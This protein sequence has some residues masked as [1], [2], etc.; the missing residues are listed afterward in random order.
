MTT[1]SA[2][3]NAANL[4]A[5]SGK[6]SQS[7]DTEDF[8]KIMITELTN[9]DPLEPMSNKDLID[10]MSGIQQI[11]STQTM[12]DSLGSMVNKFGDIATQMGTFLDSQKST[13]STLDKLMTQQKLS[14][15][16]QYIGQTVSG[17]NA[18]GKATSGR[19]ASVSI[20]QGQIFLTLESGE[21]IDMNNLSK[22]EPTADDSVTLGTVMKGTLNGQTVVGIVDSISIDGDKVLLNLRTRAE[23][24]DGTV[25][26]K[27]VQVPLDG[28]QALNVSNVGSLIGQY[29]EGY[30][31][32]EAGD[33]VHYVGHLQSYQITDQGIMLTLDTGEVLPLKDLTV[34]GSANPTS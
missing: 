1:V 2:T 8:L 6:S 27:I 10:Q 24:G 32:T 17:I 20:N 11:Q 13:L 31:T 12:T 23:N 30:S 25:S 18:D 19:V 29:I 7:I 3:N 34:I 4:L 16:S 22:L 15:A 28:A 33:P 14:T 5:T 21:Q 9:Q 26:D